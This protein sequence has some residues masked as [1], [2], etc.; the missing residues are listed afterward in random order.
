MNY[1]NHNLIASADAA[2][3][4]A[5]VVR[6]GLDRSE[7]GTRLVVGGRRD[8]GPEVASGHQELFENVLNR[9]VAG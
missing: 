3:Q 6:H 5:Q 7:Q 1:A 4:S 9:F 8:V 2:N